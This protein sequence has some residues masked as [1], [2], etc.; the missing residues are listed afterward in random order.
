VIG[1]SYTTGHP[2]GG[3]GPNGWPALAW[4]MLAGQGLPIAADVAAEGGAGYGIPGNRNNMFGALTA[5]AVRPDDG[6]VVFFG[7]RNDQPVAP[8]DLAARSAAAFALARQTAPRAR[9]LVIGPPWP[10]PAV[11]PAVLQ[12]RDVLR[13]QARAAGAT[14]FDPLAARWFVD[15]PTLIGSD[16]VHPTDAGHVYLADRIAPLIA[17]QLTGSA[18]VGEISRPG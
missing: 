13:A 9:L 12:I 1:D 4:Q 11:P 3:V 8:Q 7:S 2:M 6:L 14:F 17:A 5:E 15:T 10:T 16:G 18:V